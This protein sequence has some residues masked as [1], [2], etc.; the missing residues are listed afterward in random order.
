V[1]ASRPGSAER[2]SPPSGA[3]FRGSWRRPT[4][5]RFWAGWASTP[6]AARTA[7]G[8]SSIAVMTSSSS[9]CGASTLRPR[10]T[11][12]QPGLQRSG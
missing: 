5:I 8:P 7:S 12:G 1:P 11:A 2:A 10:R 6:T 4:W 9:V 3:T